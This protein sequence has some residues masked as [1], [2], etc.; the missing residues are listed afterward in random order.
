MYRLASAVRNRPAA[1][2]LTQTTRPCYS[3][4]DMYGRS[5]R[6][7]VHHK[8][9]LNAG[10]RFALGDGGL[11]LLRAIAATGSIRAASQHVG[12]SYRHA[13]AYLD[14]AERALDYRLIE[15]AR[16]G[17]E[18]GGAKLTPRGREFLRQYTGFRRKLDR[19]LH[20]LYRSTLAEATGED[21]R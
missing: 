19:A 3:S 7:V 10:N 18:R 4:A 6:L 8:V 11:G 14:N 15:R 9:W 17:S 16:G 13:L 5:H 2:A 20:A 21:R 12:W 1:P